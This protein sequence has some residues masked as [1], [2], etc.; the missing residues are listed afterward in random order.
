MRV[1]ALL[2]AGFV[3]VL[4][5]LAF[6]SAATVFDA[7][8]LDDR[9]VDTRNVSQNRGFDLARKASLSDAELTQT[10]ARPIF[11]PDRRPFV[12]KPQVVEQPVAHVTVVE[13]PI[14]APRRLLLLGTNVG[15]SV[16]SVLVRNQESSEVRWLK[17]GES[18]D[19]WVLTKA[20]AD[21]ATF[22][23][24]PQRDTDCEYKLLL[25]VEGGG[26]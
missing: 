19:G 16:S 15:G 10:L 23:C 14:I 5:V 13:Q 2:K 7:S 26:Q 8:A 17:L 9:A 25:Y 4:G 21:A 6:A 1:A 12:A 11:S 3:S 24:E 18:F 22:V 20:A